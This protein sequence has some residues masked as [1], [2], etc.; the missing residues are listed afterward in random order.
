M[1]SGQV[2]MLEDSV[3]S[4]YLVSASALLGLAQLCSPSGQDQAAVH[5]GTGTPFGVQEPGSARQVCQP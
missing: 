2:L 4:R 3:R 5:A 1:M